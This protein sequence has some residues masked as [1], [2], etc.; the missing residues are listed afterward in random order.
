MPQTS[1]IPVTILGGYLGA[2][3]T[4][5]V[6]HLLRNAN[7]KRL[8]I[9]VNEFGDLP[10]DA[11][12]I[13]AQDDE[14]ISLSGGCVCCSFGSDLIGAMSQMTQMKPL[15]DHII[16]EASGVALPGAILSSLSLMPGFSMD[17]IVIL[18]DAE[19]VQ[20]RARDKYMS[21]TI[22][23]QL[24]D[25]NLVLLN[26]TDL[27]SEQSLSALR[28]WVRPLAPNASIIACQD[29]KLPPDVILQDFAPDIPE[30]YGP[31]H[32]SGFASVWHPHPAPID[33]Q[34]LAEDT[35]TGTPDLV[36][37]KG[38]VTGPDGTPHT[39]QIVGKRAVVS[40]GAASETRGIIVITHGPTQTED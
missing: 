29:A 30:D 1:D 9:L 25:A 17:G 35:I 32:L 13:E 21:D 37:A 31:H 20:A 5:L 28:D 7:G 10:I 12:L 15:P 26:K 8:A 34:K 38:F 11:D 3:K 24:N 4:T 18:A 14:L 40:P 16:L 19:T 6:N 23:R 27:I 22:L 2:G 39:I 33:P 36:R